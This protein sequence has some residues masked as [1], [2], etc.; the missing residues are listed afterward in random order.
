MKTFQQE[1]ERMKI[2]YFKLYAV[3]TMLLLFLMWF[4]P[5]ELAAIGMIVFIVLSLIVSLL[6]SDLNLHKNAILKCER[7]P[8]TIHIE[9]VNINDSLSI[10]SVDVSING[11]NEIINIKNTDFF[12]PETKV[13][14]NHL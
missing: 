4:F 14:K 3:G 10:S 7:H 13:K 12:Y 9:N 6:C 1:V 2:K 8:A 11:I 5:L